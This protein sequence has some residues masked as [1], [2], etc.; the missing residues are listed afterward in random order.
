LALAGCASTPA[1][2]Q[3][4]TTSSALPAPSV[5]PLNQLAAD[6]PRFPDKAGFRMISAGI[7]G[8]LARVEVIDRAQRSLD[9]QYYIFRGDDSGKI[10]AAALLRAAERGVR[11]RLILDDGESVAGDEQILAL[12]AHPNIEIRLFNPFRYRGHWHALRAGEFLLEKPRLDYRMHNKLL[13]ADN[14]AALIGGRNIGD[15]YFQIDPT[16][17]FGDDDVL[18]VGQVVRDLSATFDEFWNSPTCVPARTADPGHASARGLRQLKSILPTA[19]PTD[20]SADTE[21]SRRLA[22]Q[23]PLQNIISGQTPLIWAGYRLV[24]DSPE[25]MRVDKGLASGSLIYVPM[26]ERAKSVHASLLIVTP[27]LV[28]TADEVKLLADQ[29]GHGVRVKILTNSLASAPD[30]AAHAG[31]GRYRRML[32]AAGIALYEIRPALG[33]PRGSGQDR[34]ISGHGNYALHAKL[35]VFDHA[36][37]FI[38]SMNLD[39]RSMHL[40][41]EIGLIIDS[42]ELAQQAADRFAALT[43]PENA[44]EVSLRRDGSKDRLVWTTREAKAEVELDREPARNSWQKF[45]ARLLSMAPLDKE[46]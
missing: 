35:F 15:Q 31:Y 16:S 39:S 36:A 2:W 38:G 42:A 19:A 24:H 18:A 40:N 44:Y 17:Q 13:V 37:V 28:P 1:T 12:A 25:K 20:S 32:L 23:Q 46:L 14:T 3:A 7:E 21:F 6:A 43:T 27:Y 45:K 10:V 33:N 11:V 29:V 41:T 22:A 8:L 30:I 9:L 5:T 26:A 34:R 4:K